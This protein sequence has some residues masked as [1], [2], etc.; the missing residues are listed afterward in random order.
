[1]AYVN[2]R[3]AS[4]SILDRFASIVKVLKEAVERRRVYVRTIQELNSLTDRDLSDLGLNRS[5]ISEV[6]HKAAYTN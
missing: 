1:M 4:V 2:S 6:A 5:L 3:S